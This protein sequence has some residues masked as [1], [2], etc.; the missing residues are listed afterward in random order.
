MV[1]GMVSLTDPCESCHRVPTASFRFRSNS[2]FVFLRR[3]Q[4]YEAM[5]CRI[6]ARRV[7][8]DMQ[9]HNLTLGW[10][11]FES[12]VGTIVGLIDNR[13]AL[14][15][16]TGSLKRPLPADP[17]IDRKLAGRPVFVRPS[18]LMVLAILVVVVVGVVT[19]G[20]GIDRDQW[21]VGACV[22]YSGTNVIVVPCDDPTAEGSVLAIIDDVFSCPAEADYF[23]DLNSGEVACLG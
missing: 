22:N 3:V 7:F 10:W 16:G 18:V 1:S 13:K 8:R 5:L 11:G 19:D 2:G 12:F 20:F 23:V 14:R 6:C 15:R 4:I 9:A 17:R 21:D